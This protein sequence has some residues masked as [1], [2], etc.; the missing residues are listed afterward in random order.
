MAGS[1]RSQPCGPVTA[2]HLPPAL[3]GRVNAFLSSHIQPG[4]H[5]LL[6]F[7]GGLDSRVLLQL[8]AE[9]RDQ[10]DFTLEA[11]HVHHSLSPNADAWAEF[12]RTECARLG[13]TFHCRHVTVDRHAGLGIEASARRA[14]YEA[15]LSVPA[16]YVMLAHHQDDQAETLMLQLLR[17]AGAKGLAGMAVHDR[18]RRLLRPLL[19]CPRAELES[20][21]SWAG[22]RWVDDE[23]NQDV[24]YD[25]NFCRHQVFPLLAQR[26]PAVSKTLARSATH[27]A[28]AAGLLNELAALDAQQVLHGN[29]LQLAM[30]SQLSDARARNLLRWWLNM[31]ALPMPGLP[32]L[33]EMLQQ[34]LQAGETALIKV[35]VHESTYLRR[36]QGMAYLSVE[37]PLPMSVD[38]SWQGEATLLLPGNGCLSCEQV[39]GVGGLSMARIQG[40]RLTVRYRS[41]GER[42][43][44]DAGRPTRT[45]KQLYQERHVPPWLRERMP[46]L[47]LDDELIVVPGIGVACGWQAQAGEQGLVVHW[48]PAGST[49]LTALE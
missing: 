35:Q 38:L 39:E 4:Q 27:L 17:G 33:Q 29:G 15:L 34:L 1:E 24:S 19:D 26:F 46:L 42:F 11:M 23:S 9:A 36:Y 21:A 18:E 44:P 2:S 25:R 32:R 14:R 5:L 31:H 22:L 12:C 45:L 10:Y 49:R 6:A 48:Q 30:L 16:D 47:F 43:K 40:H 41:G 13:V 37:L 8:L 3:P 20:Y 28:E 7:S